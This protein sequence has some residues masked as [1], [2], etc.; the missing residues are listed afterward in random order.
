MH[1]LLYERESH[2]GTRNDTLVASWMGFPGL[3]SKAEI[4]MA[5]GGVLTVST[6]I[7]KISIKI[8]AWSLPTVTMFMDGDGAKYL[9]T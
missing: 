9:E 3:Y 4:V 8:L 6:D 5:S 7:I 1:R 2:S